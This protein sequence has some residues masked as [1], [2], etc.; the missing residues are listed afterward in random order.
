[1]TFRKLVIA[2]SALAGVFVACLHA[3]WEP[4][5]KLSTSDS[6]AMLNENMGRCLV[7]CGDTLHVVWFDTQNNGS[8]I[9]YKRSSDEGTTWGP[10]TRL[11]GYPGTADFPTLAVSGPMLHLAFRDSRTGDYRSYYKRSTDGGRTWGA[12]VD[13]GNSGVFNWWPAIASVGAN[14]YVALNEDTVNSEVYFRRSTDNGTTWDTVQRISNAPGRSEDPCIAACG[15][16]IHIVWND[17]RNGGAGQSEV[18]YRRSTDQGLTWGPE[19]RLTNALGMSYS[20]TAYPSDSNVDVAWEDNR[21]TNFSIY[22]KRSTDFGLTWGSD[23]RLTMDTVGYYYPSILVDGLQIHMVWFSFAG[24][25]S[26]TFTRAM[27]A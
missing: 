21:D 3:D 19:T 11:S 15:S 1:M 24:T 5:Q 6:A 26:S 22:R 25:S 10:D 4:D 16:C 13:I 9:L 8:A 23:E 18:Y 17:F 27:G 2:A 20:P 14:V 7:A 12:D